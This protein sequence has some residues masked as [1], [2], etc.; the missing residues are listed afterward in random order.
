MP[1]TTTTTTTTTAAAVAAVAT[2]AV[3]LAAL[4]ERVAYNRLRTVTPS[5]STTTTTPTKKVSGPASFFPFV[6]AIFR[7]VSDPVGFWDEQRDLADAPDNATPGVS[8]NWLLGRLMLFATSTPICRY[9]FSTNGPDSFTL[10]LH[11][12][13]EYLLGPNN[14]AFSFGADHKRLRVSFL[15]LFT[16]RALGGYVATQ[17][18]LAR[19]HIS[20]WVRLSSAPDAPEFVEMWPFVRDLN[21]VT[22]QRVFLGPHLRPGAESQAFTQAY[23]DMTQGFLTLPIKLPGSA[24]HHAKQARDDILHVLERAVVSSKQAMSSSE[25]EPTPQ[26]LLDHWS[27][28][29]LKEVREAREA[30]VEPPKHTTDHEMACV[31]LDFLF[32]SQDAST[33]SLTWVFALLADYPDVLAKVREEQDRVRPNGEPVTYDALE[34]HMPYTRAVVKEMLRFHPPAPMMPF[35]VHQN[36]EIA[37]GLVAPKGS[38]LIADI[39]RPCARG[40]PNADT[41]DPERMLPPR[42]EDV[43]FRDHFLV[44]GAGPH[45]CVGQSYA[46]QH[47]ACFTAEVAQA[48]EWTRKRTKH[49]ETIRYLPTIVPGDC[50]IKLRWREPFGGF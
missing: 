13:A 17:D 14:I 4:A 32:A 25:A 1:T 44:F 26:C 49:T 23:L 40:F 10:A 9:A 11:P 20:E 41:F 6:G 34:N 5:S 19:E 22:S 18:Q 33:A 29:I 38:L 45:T 35:N 43:A 30:G 12:S 16:R 3:A 36:V 24:L 47:L 28:A 15:S 31:M 2:T 42:S 21:A 7:I 37:P 48:C 39:T 8:A 27:L 50:L 46:V